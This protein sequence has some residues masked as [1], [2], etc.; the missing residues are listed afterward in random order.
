[1]SEPTFPDDG[2]LWRGWSEELLRELAEKPRP[3]L[4]FVPDP[5]SMVAPFLRAIFKAMPAS[6]RLR[7]QL[8][9][10]FPALYVEPRLLPED[11][12]AFGAGSRWH[13]A[14]LS[15]YGFNPMVVFDPV[16]GD[17]AAVVNELAAVLER[18]RASWS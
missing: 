7:T 10:F 9:E 4:L 2:I 17:A 6:A 5:D 13:I 16:R 11:L 1:M 15:P 18:L 12:Q 3:V 14:I 8:N